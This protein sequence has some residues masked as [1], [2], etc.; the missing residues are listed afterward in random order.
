MSRSDC[1]LDRLYDSFGSS[2]AS[3]GDISFDVG[4]MFGLGKDDEAGSALGHLAHGGDRAALSWM[5]SVG[6]GKVVAAQMALRKSL[7]EVLSATVEGFKAPRATLS[8]ALPTIRLLLAQASQ[9]AALLSP[10]SPHSFLL[11]TA[12]AALQSGEAGDKSPD[13]AASSLRVLSQEFMDEPLCVHELLSN[14]LNKV[15]AG[16]SGPL[17]LTDVMMLVLAV[18]SLLGDEEDVDQMMD[19]ERHFIEVLHSLASLQNNLTSAFKWMPPLPERKEGITDAI[20]DKQVELTVSDAID[21][22][23]MRLRAVR[24]AR[25]L[26]LDHSSPLRRLCGD[27]RV[28]PLLQTLAALLANGEPSDAGLEPIAADPEASPSA[29]APGTLLR[30][31]MGMGPATPEAFEHVVIVVVGGV[32]F[33]EHQAVRA[34]AAR[35]GMAKITLIGTRIATPADLYNNVLCAGRQ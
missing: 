2:S 8:S 34:E 19:G 15:A 14:E 33:E 16:G 13:L 18:Y 6:V 3:G 22:T 7:M 23:A 12:C 11:R 20:W 10:S 1:F 29:S 24:D 25:K 28:R 30:N 9:N 26:A 32:T 21:E 31:F 27:G 5:Q 17:S 4:P 35:A